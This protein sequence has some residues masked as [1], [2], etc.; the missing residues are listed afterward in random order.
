MK[1]GFGWLFAVLG[2]INIIRS[3]GMF[4]AGMKNAGNVLIF[5][6]AFIGLGIWMVSSAERNKTT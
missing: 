1:K 3:I 2:V 4:D 6:I 5:S